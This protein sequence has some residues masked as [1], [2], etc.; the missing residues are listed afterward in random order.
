MGKICSCIS[1]SEIKFETS[2]DKA[3][4]DLNF[5]DIQKNKK[6]ALFIIRYYKN[7]RKRCLNNDIKQ[8]NTFLE[9]SKNFYSFD[10]LVN[11]Y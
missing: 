10:K 1:R 11:V 5:Y 7:Y 2:K 9:L 3:I 6:A 8:Y 4:G